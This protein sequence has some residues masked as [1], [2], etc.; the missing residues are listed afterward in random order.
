MKKILLL[1]ISLV[2]LLS[3]CQNET[4]KKEGDKKQEVVQKKDSVTNT[5]D[6]TKIISVGSFDIKSFNAANN[7]NA[8][9]SI[10]AGVKSSSGALA[11][12]LDSAAWKENATF[13]DSSWSRL[14][15][16]RVGKMRAW[17]DKELSAINQKEIT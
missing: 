10:L 17:R 12:Y 9:A 15:R 3:F 16:G 1:P 8:T 6:T 2:L 11:N 5:K 4:P 14:E 13:I 7:F